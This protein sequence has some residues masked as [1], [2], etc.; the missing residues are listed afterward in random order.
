MIRIGLISDTH[1]YLDPS[2][3]TH[4]QDCDEIWHI[5]DVGDISVSDALA[6]F[7]PL[8]GVY[9]NIDGPPLRYEWPEHLLLEREGLRILIIHIGGLPG[10]FPAKVKSLIKKHN[11]HL[12]ICGHSH[13]L[14]VIKGD[15]LVYINPGAAGRHG[16]HAVRTLMRMELS[17]GKI[18]HLEVVELGKR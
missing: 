2:V 6:G 8:Y 10:K 16:F 13:I 15:G 18:S 3:F 14:R 17:E 9:G 4:F 11:P 7:K 1:S 5:G 12:F